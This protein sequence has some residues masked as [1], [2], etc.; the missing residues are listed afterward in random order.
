MLS[1]LGHLT[2]DED[3]IDDCVEAGRKMRKQFKGGMKKL[4][5]IF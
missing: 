5:F 2:A 4:Y 3:F 1:V